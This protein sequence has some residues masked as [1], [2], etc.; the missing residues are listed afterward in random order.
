MTLS[1]IN[2][3][4]TVLAQLSKQAQAVDKENSQLKC[5]SVLQDNALFSKILF[6][7]YSDKFLP[8]V[9][10]VEQRT[11]ELDRLIKANKTDFAQNLISQIEQQILALLNALN[12][13]TSMHQEAAQRLSRLKSIKAKRYKKALVNVVQST[14]DL[15]QK[16]SEHH[17]FERRLLEMLNDR[18]QQR[19]QSSNATS[20][21]LSQE[22]LALHQRLGRCRHAI[23]QIERQIEYAEKRG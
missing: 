20:N 23:S 13:N 18:E 10:E 7:T 8:Y 1:A 9:R 3:I 4:S 5:H 16:L 12:A 6:T 22:V 21:T 14:Q 17:E 19:T 2:K 15:Y 11:H